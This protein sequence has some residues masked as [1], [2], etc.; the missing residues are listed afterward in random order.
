M[1]MLMLMLMSSRKLKTILNHMG[2]YNLFHKVLLNIYECW[3]KKIKFSRLIFMLVQE[4]HRFTVTVENCSGCV[5]VYT[6][7]TS[8]EFSVADGEAYRAKLSLL[9][10]LVFTNHLIHNI[11]TIETLP[12]S[13]TSSLAHLTYWMAC[14]FRC[15]LPLP[16]YFDFLCDLVNTWLT[17]VR[18]SHYPIK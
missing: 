4:Q 17:R 11:S 16:S 18:Y 6:D 10:V 2:L 5:N 12:S 14:F 8:R 9:P 1:L 7:A 13:T 15:M 3:G